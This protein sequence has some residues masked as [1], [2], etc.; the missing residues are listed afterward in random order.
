[1]ELDSPNTLTNY[2]SLSELPIIPCGSDLEQL[3]MIKTVEKN[4]VA[5]INVDTMELEFDSQSATNVLDSNLSE[6][7]TEPCESED[8]EV[9]NILGSIKVDTD[10]ASSNKNDIKNLSKE[11]IV[12]LA[13]QNLPDKI[14]T[15]LEV[16][17]WIN[18]EFYEYKISISTI[19]QVNCLIFTFT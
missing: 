2:I 17:H 1:M 15:T 8:L 14:G 4:I 13:I 6:E 5:S 9:Q 11:S 3:E 19:Y 18:K 16:F 12:A 7:S 10:L